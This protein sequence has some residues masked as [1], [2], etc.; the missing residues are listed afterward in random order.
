M[1][2]IAKNFKTIKQAEIFQF[3]LYGKFDSVKL[4]KSPMFSEE[5]IYIWEVK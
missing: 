1:K 4:V 2:T 3:N 5:G